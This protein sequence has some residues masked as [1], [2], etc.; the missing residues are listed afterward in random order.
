MTARRVLL[1]LLPLSLVLAAA[2]AGSC[3]TTTSVGGGFTD[4]SPRQLVR[5]EAGYLYAVVPDCS[6]Y[7]ECPGSALHAY[8]GKEQ[9]GSG[10]YLEIDASHAPKDGAVTT[11][12][13]LDE[14]GLVH[15]LWIARNGLARTATIDTGMDRWSA[16]TDLEDTGWTD[17]GQGEEGVALAVDAAG[18]PHA[19]WN[20]RVDGHLRIRTAIL[21]GGAWSAPET[22]DDVALGDRRQAWHPTVA[23]TPDGTLWLSWLEGGGNYTTDGVIRVRARGPDGRWGASQAIPGTAMSAID[24]GPSMLVTPDGTVHLAYC[25]SGNVVTYRYRDAGGWHGDRQPPTTRTHNPSLGPD[26]KGGVLIYG[27]GTVA[28]NDLSG[29]G[30][31][32]FTMHRPAGGDWGPWT[33]IVQGSF[34]SS[35]SV[36]WAQFFNPYPGLLDFAWWSDSYPNVLWIGLNPM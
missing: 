31:D 23:F 24:N 15:V 10:T 26:A 5:S 19:F 13:A 30:M 9:L 4:V 14:K 28:A 27:H 2:T 17:F 33:R 29:H 22:V 3:R 21:D 20:R 8:R 18:R 32:L 7:P 34:D 11:S 35:V 1:L 12:A 36:R 16:V 25:D 6:R